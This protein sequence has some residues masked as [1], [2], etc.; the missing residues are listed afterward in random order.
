LIFRRN[1][2]SLSDIELI[3]QYRKDGDKQLVGVLYK[4]YTG[5]VF[6]VCLKYLRDRAESEDAVM[7]IFDKLFND[8]KYH[9]IQNF[10]S[11]LYTVAKNECLHIIRSY[12]KAQK[13]EENLGNNFSPFMEISQNMYHD[14]E[15]GLELKIQSLERELC[16][17]A[18]EQRTCIEL[19]YIK[20]K[21]YN[22][23]AAIT[24]FTISQVKSYIQ[25]GKRNLKLSLTGN[26][27]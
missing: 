24:G 8:L 11:W 26:E 23:I 21:S 12:K 18:D 10:K 22:E 9:S 7:Q 15:D 14:S 25:N 6:A 17:L 4:R 5:F 27:Q 19:F 13:V 1:I 16:N 3:E 20:Q 2:N